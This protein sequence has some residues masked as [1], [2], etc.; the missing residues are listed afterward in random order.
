MVGVHLLRELAR[1]FRT[2]DPILA[3]WGRDLHT[4]LSLLK[5]PSEPTLAW[6]QGKHLQTQSMA[7]VGPG[8]QVTSDCPV[9]SPCRLGA[10]WCG[11]PGQRLGGGLATH[12]LNGESISLE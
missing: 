10:Q 3:P 6:L 2:G 8:E 4:G 7:T 11:G 5:D 1:N 9:G 12:L